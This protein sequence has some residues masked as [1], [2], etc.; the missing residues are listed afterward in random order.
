M[1][2]YYDIKLGEEQL[3][4][5]S[6]PRYIV[7]RLFVLDGIVSDYYKVNCQ[8]LM[9]STDDLAGAFDLRNWYEK[10]QKQGKGGVTYTYEV[11]ER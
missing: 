2:D 9:A 5:F 3:P 7:V 11:H 4:K 1:Q 6:Q 8:E 10:H